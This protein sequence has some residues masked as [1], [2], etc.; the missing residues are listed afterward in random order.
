MSTATAT[1]VGHIT[2]VIGSTF[3]VEFPENSIPAIYN[4]VLRVLRA[5]TERLRP[6]LKRRASL[7]WLGRGQ[8]A[9]FGQLG[10]WSG[11]FLATPGLSRAILS[12]ATR[13]RRMPLRPCPDFE[14]CFPTISSIGLLA[15]TN[16]PTSARGLNTAHSLIKSRLLL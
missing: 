16:L 15:T 6:G 7:V 4:A 10:L 12:F 9:A 1:N 2:Q 11:P 5:S 3:D 14:P 8:C 13:V